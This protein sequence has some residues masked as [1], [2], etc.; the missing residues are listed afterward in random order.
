MMT[1][2]VGPCSRRPLLILRAPGFLYFAD[3]GHNNYA[4]PW[5]VHMPKRLEHVIIF[6]PYVFNVHSIYD[7]DVNCVCVWGL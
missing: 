5:N 4:T 3:L 6:T 7:V 1:L 2:V